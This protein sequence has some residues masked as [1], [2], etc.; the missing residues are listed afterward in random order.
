MATKVLPQVALVTVL[1]MAIVAVPQVSLAV[2]VPKVS[3]T[4]AHSL[5]WLAGQRVKVGA[6][7]SRVAMIWLHVVL[8]PH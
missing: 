8:L 4:P 6:V 5:V 2:G 3:A 7:V 1:T